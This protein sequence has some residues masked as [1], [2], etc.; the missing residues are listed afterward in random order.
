MT[1]ESSAEKT[2]ARGLRPGDRSTLL[3]LLVGCVLL[4][5]GYWIYH[6]GHRGNLVEIDRAPHLKARFVVD[7]NRADWP[8]I[9]QL[10]GLGEK[11]ARRI[12]EDRHKNGPFQD[13]EDLT[14]VQGIGAGTLDKI[15]PYV[16]TVP[17]KKP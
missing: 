17:V 11:L 8:E 1:D 9:I 3:V 16:T 14:R 7:L 5:F 6:G 15:R 13:V 12:L 4:V 2:V 10:P